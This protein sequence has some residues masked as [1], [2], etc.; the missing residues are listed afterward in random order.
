MFSESPRKRADF[1]DSSKKETLKD[2]IVPK[3]ALEKLPES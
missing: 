3:L 2:L 1:S